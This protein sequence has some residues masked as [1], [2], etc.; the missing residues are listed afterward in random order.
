MLPDKPF[1]TVVADP[2]SLGAL[3]NFPIL[4]EADAAGI[5]RRTLLKIVRHVFLLCMFIFAVT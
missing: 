1:K 4:A 3:T 5:L 2:E